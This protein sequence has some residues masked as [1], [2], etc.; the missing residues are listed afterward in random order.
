M[1]ERF[2]ERRKPAEIKWGRIGK[3]ICRPR[4][5]T[6]DDLKIFNYDSLNMAPLLGKRKRRD[7][8]VENAIDTRDIHQDGHADEMAAR[9][10][11]HFEITFEPLEG[12][13]TSKVANTEVS[14]LGGQS[15]AEWD[16]CSDGEQ[17]AVQVV[18]HSTLPSNTEIPKEELSSFMVRSTDP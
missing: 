8:V 13:V 15:D 14:D 11:Q 16:G 6:F 5:S 18:D 9:L 17:K 7:K 1:E 2:N 3:S 12:I 4:I 10:R